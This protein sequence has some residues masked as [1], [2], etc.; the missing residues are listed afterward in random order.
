MVQRIKRAAADDPAALREVLEEITPAIRFSVGDTL[1]RRVRSAARSRARHE[2]ED[3]TQE[4]LYALLTRKCRRLQLWDPEKGLSLKRYVELVSRH[5]V[6]AFLRKRERRVWDNDPLEAG[7][8]EH[9][10]DTAESPEYL[11]ARKE[12]FRAI[13]ALVDAELTRQGREIFRLLVLDGQ[14]VN[15]VCARM[16][17]TQNAVHV[18]RSRLTERVREAKRRLQRGA[19]ADD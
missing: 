7:G 15:E 17:I 11:V 3:L 1:R 16:G 8:F 4:V 9:L 18:W 19:F 6:E 10:A 12:T 13:F 5:L 14:S 2:I